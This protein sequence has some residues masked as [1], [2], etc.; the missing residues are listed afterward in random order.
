MRTAEEA[1]HERRRRRAARAR[2][3]LEPVDEPDHAV[4][5]YR[6]EKPLHVVVE[7]EQP[8]QAEQERDG[9]EE[10][11][12]RA[13]G[14]LLGEARAVVLEEPLPRPLEDVDPLAEGESTR[15][16]RDMTGLGRAEFSVSRG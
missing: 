12:H 9:G 6:V 14:D 7:V 10:R 3:L 11:E 13:E 4:R 16:R 2:V 15:A 8:E 5:R 1:D